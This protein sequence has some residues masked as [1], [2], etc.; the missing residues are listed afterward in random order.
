MSAAIPEIAAAGPAGGRPRA[1]R[2]GHHVRKS[3]KRRR[4]TRARHRSPGW[5]AAHRLTRVG[6][7]HP[8]TPAPGGGLPGTT[9]TAPSAPAGG[10]PSS[11]PAGPQPPASGPPESQPP[12]TGPPAPTSPFSG[13]ALY[14][15]PSSEA[16]ATESEW[17]GQGRT[18]EAGEIAKIARQPLAEW[19]G[20]WSY[21]H[22][23]TEADV[24]WWVGLASAAK[25]LPVLVAYDA[26][27]RDCNQYSS[28][29][30][31]SPAAYE[32][33]IEGMSRGIAGRPA[34][35]ILE[36]DALAELTC[37]TPEHQASYYS[38]L[39]N[40]VKRLSSSPAT[41][42]YLDAGNAGWQTAGTMA[43]RLRQAD[44]SGAR[45]FSLN[46][47]N[48]DTT[49]SET[50]YGEAISKELGGGVHFVVDTSRNG[51]GPAPGGAWCNPPGRGLGTAPTGATGNPLV[52]AYLWVKRPGES[53]GTC[54]GGP[55]AGQWWPAYALELA[56]NAAG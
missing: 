4:R 20:D 32:Q 16:A 46:V 51:R 34:V 15:Y 19:F 56:E 25:A 14:V 47:S 12:E 22:G 36:P 45:G 24:S 30:A 31:A 40:A 50:A 49:V 7:G 44:V 1:A 27:W 55:A 18:A 39:T 35:V 9:P 23:S 17:L 42:V 8:S 21:G 6:P 48:F 11:P 3:S 41:S 5:P 2:H 38:L 54:N 29:G 10:P 33:F 28:G 52:D 53:D 13:R 43:A 37:L 26:P